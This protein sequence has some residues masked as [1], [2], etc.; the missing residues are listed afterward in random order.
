MAL[1]CVISTY[2]SSLAKMLAK[3]PI[4]IASVEAVN[5]L[6]LHDDYRARNDA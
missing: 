3:A 5:G 2:Y 1:Q 4:T 6:P